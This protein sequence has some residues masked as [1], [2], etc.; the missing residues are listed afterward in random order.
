MIRSWV[1]HEAHAL[2]A[3]REGVCARGELGDSWDGLNETEVLFNFYC[4]L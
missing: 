1:D 2:E 3:D 4:C